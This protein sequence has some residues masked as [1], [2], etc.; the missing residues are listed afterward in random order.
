[1]TRLPLDSSKLER[2]GLFPLPQIAL[3]P[4]ALLPLFVF[5]P[6]YKRLVSDAITHDHY[7]AVPRLVPGFESNYGGAPPVFPICGVGEILQHQ[8]LDNG[9]FRI[10]LR[11]LMRARILDEMASWPF[12]VARTEPVEDVSLAPLGTAAALHGELLSLLSRFPQPLTES[13][14][15]LRD[16]TR[17]LGILSQPNNERVR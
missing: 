17:Q 1:M 7:I 8:E 15:A 3:F 4:G 11:G 5:E 13:A 9:R 16:S 10:A 2:V 6:R 14:E 12:R